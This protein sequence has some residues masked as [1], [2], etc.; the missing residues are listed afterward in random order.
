MPKDVTLEQSFVSL[1]YTYHLVQ[2]KYGNCMLLATKGEIE[3][4]TVKIGQDILFST[5]ESLV[6]HGKRS[7][8]ELSDRCKYTYSQYI[9]KLLVHSGSHPFS[10]KMDYAKSHII[11]MDKSKFVLS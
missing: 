3:V 2:L 9:D 7:K 6:R 4:I 10:L 1:T 8:E 11:R 5:H